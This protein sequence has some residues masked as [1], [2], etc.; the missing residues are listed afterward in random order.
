MRQSASLPAILREK[1]GQSFVVPGVERVTPVSRGGEFLTRYCLQ[2]V[3]QILH[4]VHADGIDH[5]GRG[6]ANRSC[7]VPSAHSGFENHGIHVR[8]ADDRNGERREMLEK[9]GLVLAQFRVGLDRADDLPPMGTPVGER[10][11]TTRQAQAFL[12]GNKVRARIKG[13]FHSGSNQYSIHHRGRRT[14]AVGAQY[15]YRAHVF[16]GVS[17]QTKKPRNP[18][19]SGTDAE[20]RKSRYLAG[21]SV[22]IAKILQISAKFHRVP[23]PIKTLGLRPKARQG[24]CS[25]HPLY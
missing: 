1:S 4:V 24:D 3:A 20:A 23:T 2:R 12:K 5:D 17:H 9:T 11:K 7:V 8:L 18:P 21:E 10:H 14:L 6:V 19:Q 16:F 22:E 25:P 13:R 15:L